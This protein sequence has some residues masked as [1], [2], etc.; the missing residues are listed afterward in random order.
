[1]NQSGLPTPPP[2][3]PTPNPAQSSSSAPSQSSSDVSLASIVATITSAASS[4]S[5][6]NQ[7]L[8]NCAS[9]DVREVLLASIL[10]GS[11]DPLT[12]LTARDHTL[13]MLYILSARL[14]SVASD[15]P[16]W[17]HIES[18][19]RDFIPEHA[20]V[21]PDR[22]TLLATGIRQLADVEGNPKLA[23]A[24][25]SDLLVKYPP[26]LSHL[27]TIHPIFVTACV[28]TRHFK[29]AIPVLTHPITT[30]DLSLSDLT[31]QDNLIYHY[32]GGIA[33]AALKDW[34]AAEE[35][36]EICASSPGSVA[37]AIQ[38]EALKK[39]ALVQLIYR[40]KTSPPSKYMHPVLL[41]LFKATPYSSF[42]NAYPLQRD[43]LRTIVENEQ[44]LF[45]NERTLGLITQALNRAPRWAIKKLT[46]TYLTLHLSD[47]GRQVGISDET[48][49][50]SLILSMIECSEI[51]AELFADGTVSFSDPPV[52]F[53]KSDVDRVLAQAQQQ[54]A[55]LVRLEKEMERNK[56]YLTKAVKSKDDASWPAMDEDG[57]FGERP[58]G[59]W[60]ED[61]TFA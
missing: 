37:S 12:L 58:P 54:D 23:I 55:L 33:F 42:M 35:L 59:T 38:M 22:V 4:P 49:V 40:G 2:S 39:L 32:A 15:K 14:H 36:F 57:A 41:R 51:S 53:E 17:H 45:T 9:K 11:Q 46:T 43:Y 1:M 3:T 19:C 26:T 5:H 30:I 31:Y 20:R 27:T 61:M 21:A 25:L 18:F 28:A 34:P 7:Y 10:P 16:L 56:E 13:G 8:R 60:A 6:L 47:I 24:P 48:E 50:K 52:K 29:S 44:Q